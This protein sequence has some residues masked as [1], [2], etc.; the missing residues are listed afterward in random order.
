MIPLYRQ[1]GK[2]IGVNGGVS[3]TIRLTMDASLKKIHWSN[4]LKKFIGI[5][6]KF[7]SDLCFVFLSGF[8]L[9]SSFE[10]EF[11]YR[12]FTHFKFLDLS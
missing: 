8:N 10:V 1:P 5:P 7:S 2:V 11:F 6:S 3:K 9:V 12:D 4:Y